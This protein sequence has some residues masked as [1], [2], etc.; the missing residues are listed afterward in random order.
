MCTST[1]GA[2]CRCNGCFGGGGP[3]PQ[4]TC[5]KALISSPFLYFGEEMKNLLSLLGLTFLLLTSFNTLAQDEVT[6][7]LTHPAA[8]DRHRIFTGFWDNPALTGGGGRNNFHTQYASHFGIRHTYVVGQDF[9]LGEERKFAMGVA[10]GKVA[11]GESL[12]NSQIKENFL[13]LTFA[14][15]FDIGELVIRPGIGLGYRIKILDF[16]QLTFGDM[17]DPR[18]GF[19]YQSQT[20]FVN[21]ASGSGD[22]NIGVEYMYRNLFLETVMQHVTQPN[23]GIH[24]RPVK[25]VREFLIHSGIRLKLADKLIVTPYVL[26]RI[27]HYYSSF[28]PGVLGEIGE[29]LL[30]GISYENLNTITLNTGLNFGKVFRL[31]ASLGVITIPRWREV[32]PISYSKISMTLFFNGRNGG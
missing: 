31:Q 27:V 5:N 30:L 1:S 26:S 19:I 15:R 28:T 22:L 24:S 18:Y 13:L 3:S 6:S 10:Y 12:A 32:M 29:K 16:T 25:K 8:Q 4:G 21:S 9:R 20:T 14:Y 23:E 2:Y 11:E 7:E 17:I